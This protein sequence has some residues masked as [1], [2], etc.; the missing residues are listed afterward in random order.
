MS[1]ILKHWSPSRWEVEGSQIQQIQ[2]LD[3]CTREH[4]LEMTEAE[5]TQIII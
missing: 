4:D 2:K 3:A 1:P 5:H